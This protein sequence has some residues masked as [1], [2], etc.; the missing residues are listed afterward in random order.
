MLGISIKTEGLQNRVCARCGEEKPLREFNNRK[1]V[2]TEV[3]KYK[4]IHGKFHRM[5]TVSRLRQT[6]QNTNV[7]FGNFL[8]S[9]NV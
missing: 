9:E 5:R 2:L 6:A 1:R 4:L 7:P 3:N 8:M